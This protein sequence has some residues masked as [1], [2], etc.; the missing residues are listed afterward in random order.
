MLNA[1]S[2]SVALSSRGSPRRLIFRLHIAT[3]FARNRPSLFGQLL[4]LGWSA[5]FGIVKKAL[6][7]ARRV[8]ACEP[9]LA[10]DV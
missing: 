3:L 2:A 10:L 8:V 7:F 5:S 1:S 6:G 4:G 9:N